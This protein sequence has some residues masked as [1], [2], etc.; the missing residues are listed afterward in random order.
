MRGQKAGGRVWIRGQA[1]GDRDRCNWEV[2]KHGVVCE[3]RSV[4]SQKAE[5]RDECG[6]EVRK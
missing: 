3:C 5:Q 2:R 4:G 6:R 1:A